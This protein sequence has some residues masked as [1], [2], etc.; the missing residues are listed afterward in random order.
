MICEQKNNPL[1]RI[2]VL[3]RG[4]RDY[5]LYLDV[6]WDFPSERETLWSAPTSTTLID[7]IEWEDAGFPET[8]YFLKV[9]SGVDERNQSHD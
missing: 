1:D 2:Y 4:Q 9:W 6:P 8:R 5:R 7:L 3:V